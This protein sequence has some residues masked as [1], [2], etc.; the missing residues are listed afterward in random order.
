MRTGPNTRSRRVARLAAPFCLLL[1]LS[2]CDESS[3]PDTLAPITSTTSTTP[4]PTTTAPSTTTSEPV[5]DPAGYEEVWVTAWGIAADPSSTA[6]DL[7]QVASAEAATRLDSM[8]AGSVERTITN[9]PVVSAPDADGFVEINDC[10]LSQPPFVGGADVWFRGRVGPDGNG[11]IRVVSMEP[12][13]SEGCVP[14]EIAEAAIADYEDYLDAYAEIFQPP[15]PTS[16]R[17]AETTTGDQYEHLL[18]LAT[19]HAESGSELRW[20]PVSHPEI[21]EFRSP[22]ELVISD[23]QSIGA[24]LGVF[25][26]DSGERLDEVIPPITEGQRDQR[27]MVMVLEDDRWKVSEQRGEVDVSCEFAPTD[28]GVPVVGEVGT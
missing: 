5:P 19:D 2:A 27:S 15:D 7:E 21:T 28:V 8:I 12:V 25:D 22:T 13:S 14:A 18:G 9:H 23:C 6:A 26:M 20:R 16:P 1:V 3:T 4:A 17:I 24:E 10:M 11:A